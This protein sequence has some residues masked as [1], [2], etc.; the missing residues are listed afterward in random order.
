MGVDH[1]SRYGTKRTL[2]LSKMGAVLS[3]R[4][5]ASNLHFNS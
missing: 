5:T 1:V 3:R 2:A 4:V